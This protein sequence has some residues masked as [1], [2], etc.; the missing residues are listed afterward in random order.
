M[1]HNI[2][3]AATAL[4]LFAFALPG[5]AGEVDFA[6]DIQPILANK[7]TTCHGPDE[8]KREADLRLDNASALDSGVIE[9]GDP[10]ESELIRRL[11]SDDSDEMMPP[12]G[13]KNPVTKEEIE[14]FRKWIADGAE[15]QGHW[16]FAAPARSDVPQGEHLVD[17]FI[18]ARL[19]TEKLTPAPEANR[20][21]LLRR[22][23]LDLTG[24]PPTLAELDAF[25]ADK[26]PEAYDKQVERLLASPHYGERWARWWLDAARYADSDGFEK[27]LPRQQWAWRD[28]VI[29]AFN[30][31]LPYNQFIIHQLAGD[32]LPG[33]GQNERVATGF[34]RNSMVNEEGAIIPEEFRIE[35]IIDRI[36][37]IGKAVLGM[38]TACAQCH[39]HKYDPLSQ[40]EY[41]QIFAYLNNNYESVE[42]VYSPEHKK[43]MERIRTQV[44]EQE[45]KLKTAVPEWEKKLA[46]WAAARAAKLNAESWNGLKPSSAEV[47]DGICH[48]ELLEDGTVLNLGFRPTATVL[49][50]IVDTENQDMTGLKLEALKHGDLIFGG[51][52]RNHNGG[53]AI[54]EMTV[55]AA[56]LSDPEKFEKLELTA[57]ADVAKAEGLIEPYLRHNSEDR[58]I[59][60]GGHFLVDGDHKTAWY[61]D[62][63]PRWRNEESHA[64]LRFKKPV[65]H[66]GGTRFKI[67]MAF[68]HGGGDAHG[69]KNNF[70]GRFRF[71]TTSD[72]EPKAADVPAESRRALAK[73]ADQR[74]SDDQRIL[75]RQW[76]RSDDDGK[77]FMKQIDSL[78][79][80]WPDGDSVLNLA[81]RTAEHRRKTFIFERGNWQKQ[82]DEVGV[83]VPAAFHPLPENSPKNRL[84]F[85]R[86]LVDRRSPLAARVIVNRVW[87]AY[88]GTGLVATA[89]DMGIR[90]ELPTH[91]KL[92]DT[93]A[94]ELMEPTAHTSTT[95]PTTPWSLK[96]LHR[97][98]VSSATYKQSSRATAKAL[99]R[100]PNNLLLARGPRFR[101]NA[102]MI[103]DIALTASGLIN[104]D[105]GGPSIFPP[106]PKGLF[107]L[108]F[109]NVDFWK[110][111]TG[112]ERY[113]RS[114][115]VFRRR[116]IP[117]PVLASFDAPTGDVSCVRR[118][119]SNTPLAAL[120]SLNAT[121]FTEAAQA[122]AL[123]IIRE[124][125]Q[126]D[127]ER[128]RYGFRLCTARNPSKTEA[129]TI[130]ALLKK[131][132]DRLV[133]GDLK[134]ADIAF[135]EFTK[136]GDLPANATP[137]DAAAWTVIARVL[138]NLDATLSKG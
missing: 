20:A 100:D 12:P 54:S 73:S 130:A 5:F 82:T 123:R 108:S 95:E 16:A 101:G 55:R 78:W 49:T 37:C 13:Q 48:P 72:K 117:D 134:A 99:K 9:P 2:S 4:S 35:G 109:V 62:R 84:S 126:T 7:C 128:I 30:R 47:P 23:S 18:R 129:T 19:K 65:S 61:P 133:A 106:A 26:S 11:L 39:D 85:A 53:F 60:G 56:P 89:E 69:R 96:H 76:A 88:F 118:V 3:R 66:E 29:N 116:S 31:D 46:E 77:K 21:A 136:P 80:G 119:L 71:S 103:R 74:T 52:G 79:T 27:D 1:K 135:N 6:R 115:Y 114:L 44:L 83:G 93:L 34:L 97:L 87:Q 50:V 137:N 63:G 15:Y 64:V 59:V 25:L 92:L 125:G 10:D 38:S 8:A 58:R 98:I 81:N 113:R 104:R 32:L 107:D 42:R 43:T 17:T 94:V 127:E 105:I 14:L 111:A 131:T 122:L 40:R 132:R 91:P 120:T 138:L 121:I 68:R 102:E 51:P 33:A 86:W 124:G 112:P 36:D 57:T 24:L 67:A 70:I 41:Y 110:T 75:L 22:L 90:A 28:W 45:S